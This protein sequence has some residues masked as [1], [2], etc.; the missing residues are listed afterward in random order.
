MQL[1]GFKAKGDIV[2]RRARICWEFAPDG[3]ETLADIPHV[4]LRRK[5][6][7]F[8]FPDRPKDRP[9]PYQVYDSKS[10]PPAP[11]PG[12]LTVTDL[13]SWEMTKKNG[14]RTLFEPISVAV[15]SNGRFVE[16]LRR[17]IGTIYSA[18]GL[19]VRQTVE[20]LDV[21]TEPGALLA[22]T[23]YYYQVFGDDL[24]PIGNDAAPYR[25]SAM[26]TDGYGL[27][28]TLYESLPEIYRRHDVTARP[29]TPGFDS[30]PELSPGPTK[31]SG[32]LRRFLDP[33]GLALELHA[34]NCRGVAHA[35]RCRWRRCELLGF[36]R[37]LDRLGSER[38][39]RDSGSAQ[40]AQGCKATLRSGR[41]VA[42]TART[43]DPAHRLVHADR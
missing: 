23:V 33:F 30:V 16:I 34:R 24:P 18:D 19:P 40:R 12:E 13:P 25:G 6:R 1:A 38:R 26:V 39:H 35:A 28:R 4:H 31:S 42:G 43:R 27:N 15:S 32:Q 22:N 14:E 36:A 17:T 7:D 29:E 3:S 10:F 5:R 37:A 21:G 9:D 41:H 11:I 8:A 20:I 2:G